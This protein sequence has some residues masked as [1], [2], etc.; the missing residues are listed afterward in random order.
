MP[1]TRD[2]FETSKWLPISF[3]AINIGLLYV[4]YMMFHC[5]PLLADKATAGRAVLDIMFFNSLTF[6]IVLSFIRACTTHPGSIPS[7]DDGDTTWE[8][9]QPGI[10]SS[11][12]SI[13]SMLGLGLNEVKKSGERRHCKWCAKYKPDRAHHCRACRT[14]ILKMDHH[15]PWIGSCV[16][17]K[18]HKF[19]FLTLF[20]STIATN[21]IV[22][23]MLGSVENAVDNTVSFFSMF[24]L[25]FGETLASFLGLVV[26]VF[27]VFHIWLMLKATTTI[28]FCEKSMKRT[29][30]TSVYNRGYYGNLCAVLGDNPLLWLWPGSPP[31]GNGINFSQTENSNLLK[32]M[33]GGRGMKKKKASKNKTRGNAGTGEYPGSD[34]SLVQSNGGPES[35]LSSTISLTSQKGKSTDSA[36]NTVEV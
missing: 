17:F 7:K 13:S 20:Y 30:D 26:T 10:F 27:F 14:C 3:V 18:N 24:M 2:S 23:T 32:Y 29:W 12:K 9:K 21:M 4:I 11:A 19:F 31:S 36:R 8:Y 6:M 33:E 16:G 1:D 25:I 34:A 22:W 28:E 5:L 35:P 15:C